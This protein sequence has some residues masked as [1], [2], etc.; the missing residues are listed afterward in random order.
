MQSVVVVAL[1]DLASDPQA[2]PEVRARAEEALVE[3]GAMLERGAASDTLGQSI[4]RFHERSIQAQHEAPVAAPMPP[5]QPIGG[6][7][8]VAGWS[9]CSW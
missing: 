3:I 1:M 9:S 6:A 8:S 4:R 5:G 2:T 7:S